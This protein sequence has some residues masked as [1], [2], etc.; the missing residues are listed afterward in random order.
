ML[1][2][3]NQLKS[4]ES[5]KNEEAFVEQCQFAHVVVTRDQSIIGSCM[6]VNPLFLYIKF[7]KAPFWEHLKATII[8]MQ[9]Y[10]E[11]KIA[12]Y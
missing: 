7:K 1:L 10:L 8:L 5:I 11:D 12:H 3:H 6:F 2:V 4:Q 9:P